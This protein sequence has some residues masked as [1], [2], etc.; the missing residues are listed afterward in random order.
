MEKEIIGYKNNFEL[1]KNLKKNPNNI[2]NFYQ[3]NHGMLSNFIK[4]F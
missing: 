2:K 4:G 3:K 1:L